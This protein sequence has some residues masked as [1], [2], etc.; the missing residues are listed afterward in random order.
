M[1]ERSADTWQKGRAANQASAI[2][3]MQGGQPSKGLI[4]S[5]KWLLKQTGERD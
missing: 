4:H 2:R 5:E 3:A 1:Q